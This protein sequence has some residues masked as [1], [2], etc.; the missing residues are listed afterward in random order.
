MWVHAIALKNIKRELLQQ[1][2]DFLDH[3]GNIENIISSEDNGINLQ[4]HN[5]LIDS[6]SSISSM[7]DDNK[8]FVKALGSCI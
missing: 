5:K 3:N 1:V 7:N 2:D 4:E 8:E 6:H